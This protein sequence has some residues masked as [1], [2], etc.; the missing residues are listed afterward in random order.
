MDIRT[1]V[2]APA[3]RLAPNAERLTAALRGGRAD[4]TPNV[5]IL[6]DPRIVGLILDRPAEKACNSFS[7][8]PEDHVELSRCTAQDAIHPL[9]PAC[10]D[11]AAVRR[12][13]GNRFCLVGNLNVA[14]VL[15]F[16][17]PDDVRRAARELL[18][19]A[20]ATAPTCWPP[21]TRSWTPSRLR[22]TWPLSRRP[23][24]TVGS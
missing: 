9:Q 3:S 13:W 23:C 4:R 7:V 24:C 15:A 17:S 10:N 19:G 16:G 2:D 12:Q 5:E 20:G 18:E 8:A 21:A 6:M 14:G 22:T 11:I 1:T